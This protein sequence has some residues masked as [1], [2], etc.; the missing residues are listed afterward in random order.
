MHLSAVS[1]GNLVGRKPESHKNWPTTIVVSVALVQDTTFEGLLACSMGVHAV[2]ADQ[3]LL[4]A[5]HVGLSGQ[6]PA[7]SHHAAR[8]TL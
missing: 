8:C 2:H 1:E 6:K 4:C 5:F 7:S 3:V